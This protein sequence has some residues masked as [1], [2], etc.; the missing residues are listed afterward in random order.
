MWGINGLRCPSVCHLLISEV[1]WLDVIESFT[2]EHCEIRNLLVF[3]HSS[4]EPSA[5]CCCSRQRE[6]L[7][8]LD[9]CSRPSSSHR[10][11]CRYAVPCVRMFHCVMTALQHHTLSI[12]FAGRFQVSCAHLPMPARPGTTVSFRL[13]PERRCLRTSSSSQLVIRRTLLSTVG[14]HAFPVAGSSL[15]ISLPPDIT[16]ASMLSVFRNHLKTHLFSRSSPS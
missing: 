11:R 14:D 5:S 16:S 4:A 13:H 6:L 3:D 2:A 8:A 7:A 1:S 15:W 12:P 9:N 10:Q